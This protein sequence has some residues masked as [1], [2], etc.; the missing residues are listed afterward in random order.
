MKLNGVFKGRSG[1]LIGLGL[2]VGGS[3]LLAAATRGIR[4]VARAMLHGCLDMAGKLKG[5][6]TGTTH[7]GVDLEAE[8]EVERAGATTAATGA[9]TATPEREPTIPD[10]EEVT[11]KEI[12]AWLSGT[13]ETSDVEALLAAERS[14][15][16]RKT[17][18]EAIEAR[19]SAL[20]S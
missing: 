4:P 16:A 11:V 1:I 17:A 3:L 9:A 15:K 13:E 5:F 20:A 12:R 14:S 7:R 10:P 6:G 19:L 2:A 18:I 8:A